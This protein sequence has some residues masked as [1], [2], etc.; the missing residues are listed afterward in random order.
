[1]VWTKSPTTAPFASVRPGSWPARL[2]LV[3]AATAA[4]TTA[5]AFWLPIF[6]VGGFVYTAIDSHRGGQQFVAA[7]VFPSLLAVAA[8]SLGRRV[9]GAAVVAAVAALVM[10]T[11]ALV[12]HVTEAWRRR[13]PGRFGSLFELRAGFF[14]A[15]IAVA[16][17]AFAF[18]AL[19]RMLLARGRDGVTVTAAGDARVAAVAG[20]VGLML[21]IAGQLSASSK[22][23]LWALPLLPQI[24]R[25]WQLIVTTS[26]CG[27][28]LWQR[29]SLAL[30]AAVP[31]A[32]VGAVVAAQQLVAVAALEDDPAV[33]TTVTLLGFA[34]VAIAL[35][36]A[37]VRV[38]PRR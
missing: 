25:W 18:G 15:A 1:M 4:A 29:S 26:L 31:V 3:V 35:T 37:L 34:L 28:A 8:L 2:V 23:H 6:Q 36:P 11:L 12:D 22:A 32:L 24:G 7:V 16:G 27:I 5:V 9:E 17:G 10:V 30:A 20:S 14:V 21:A 13:D 38:V 19:V 33:S